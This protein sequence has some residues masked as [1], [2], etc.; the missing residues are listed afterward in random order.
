MNRYQKAMPAEH[1]HTDGL[2]LIPGFLPLL[3][4]NQ[5]RGVN[6]VVY[7]SGADL[8]TR[9]RQAILLKIWRQ[10]KD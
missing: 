2:A 8:K 7:R 6:L 1:S 9:G 3:S 4:G 5:K 10:S